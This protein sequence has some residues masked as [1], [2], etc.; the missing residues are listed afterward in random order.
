MGAHARTVVLQRVLY[1]DVV[2][3]AARDA[4]SE[5]CDFE[6]ATAESEISLTIVPRPEA[7]RGVV[8]E[9]LN[10]ALC[11]ALEMHLSGRM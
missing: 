2:V 1:P 6:V 3:A 10:Y 5:L 8:D 9:F 11:A 7:S 4:Y